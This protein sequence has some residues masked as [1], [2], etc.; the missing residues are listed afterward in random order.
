VPQRQLFSTWTLNVN[1][2]P[3]GAPIPA[4]YVADT[5]ADFARRGNGW[6]YG[7]NGDNTTTARDRDNSNSPDQRYDTLVH[8]QE[9]VLP[10]AF[11]ELAV[12][13]GRYT[14]RIVAGDP[15]RFN[16]VYRINVDGVLAINATAARGQ[17]WVEDTVTVSVTDGRLTI[18]N[19]SGASNNKI[20]FVDITQTPR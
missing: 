13:N 8:M 7:W 9:R 12:P 10:D 15:D 16:S 2:Q 20:C 18:S 5:G 3:A 4:G 1:F 17:R 11:W 6:S 19:A 14:V